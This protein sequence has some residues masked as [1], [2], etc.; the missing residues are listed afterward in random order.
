M[1]SLRKLLASVLLSSSAAMAQ[2]PGF[3]PLGPE[4]AVLLELDSARA[5]R[6]NSIL[7]R[8]RERL[9]SARDQIGEPIDA[10]T[11]SI[12]VAAAEAIAADAD[13]QLARVLTADEMEI[14]RAAIPRG[15]RA[16][17]WTNA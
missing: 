7:H 16:R 12:L 1:A 3:N 8:A 6:V 13:Q 5:Q 15:T 11:Y 2:A 14:W 9:A 4:V 10:S 17:Q